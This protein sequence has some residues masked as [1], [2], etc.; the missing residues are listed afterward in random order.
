M[1]KIKHVLIATDF[2][3]PSQIAISRAVS[4]AKQC[5]AQITLLHVAKKSFFEQVIAK[6]I[7]VISE[8]LISPEEY[9]TSLLKKMT[10]Q[11]SKDKIKIKYV[12]LSGEEPAKKILQYTKN[13]K[14]TLLIIGSHDKY[15]V[16]DWFVGTTAEYIARKTTIPVLIIKNKL[17]KPY[18]KILIPV[19]FSMTSKNALL[20]AS[21]LF[22]SAKLKLLHAHDYEFEKLIK[23]EKPI[24]QDKTNEIRQSILLLLSDKMKEFIISC[25]KKLSKLTFDVKLGHPGMTIVQEA[26]KSKQDLIIMGTEGHSRKHYLFIGRTASRVLIE[27][28]R[29]LLLVPPHNRR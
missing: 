11:Y 6:S 16:H 20:F 2:S 23:N 4:L 5:K 24:T 1:Q 27:I 22:P 18:Q 14:N 7:P 12:I 17:Q 19:D 15:S 10:Q 3:D 8:I 26:K 28:D 9:A 29:D 21:N 25:H 13:K